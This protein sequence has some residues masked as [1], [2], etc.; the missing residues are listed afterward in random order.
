[1]SKKMIGIEIGADSVKIAQVKNG[2]VLNMAVESLPDHMVSN[3]R[4]TAPAAMSYFLKDMLKR[5][6][7]RGKD[8]AFVIP[9]QLVISQRVTL[10]LMTEAELKLNL[11][12]EFK[13]YVGRNSD[14]YAYD[15]IV[16]AIRGN[17]MDLYTAAVRKDIM[18]E[19]YNIF[20]RAGLTLRM[21]MPSELAWL[22]VIRNAPKSPASLCII[23]IGHEKTHINIYQNGRFVMGKDI[24]Y[25][26][27]LFDEAIAQELEVD[28]YAA[29]TLK[30]SDTD[31]IQSSENLKQPFG[32]VAIEVMKT[33]TF[34]S[35]SDGTDKE[36]L[37]D[38]Y[39]CGGSANIE[40]LRTAIVKATDLVPHH[41]ARLLNMDEEL[42][43]LAIRC[44][45]AAGA[46]MQKE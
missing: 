16:S 2:K 35:Y 27:Q 43:P 20:K 3:G 40:I 34:Y 36:P 38:M 42:I 7:I 24:E 12:Y 29:R 23:D 33:L 14:D 46:A 5:Y 32:A 15:Y 41:V 39:L 21:A 10:P 31:R 30:E 22:N 8:C 37:R 19:Y 9:P 44:G 26:G 4:V 11:P 17:M 25:A 18:E 45:L 6:K 1:M 28:S 13:D